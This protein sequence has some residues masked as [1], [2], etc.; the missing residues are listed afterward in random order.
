M[1]RLILFLFFICIIGISACQTASQVVAK[2]DPFTKSKVITLELWHKVVDGT[3]DNTSIIYRREIKDSQSIPSTATFFFRAVQYDLAGTSLQ[4][5]SPTA[6]ILIKDK[7]YKVALTDLTSEKTT[8][9][10]VEDLGKMIDAY[11]ST[12]K[13]LRGKISFTPE[14]EKQILEAD[15]LM[16]RFYQGDNASTLQAEPDQLAKV[17]EFLSA[18]RVNK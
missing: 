9:I 11:S 8:R 16:Y 10:D 15:S 3:L 18:G 2:D 1:K 17:K 12:W 6:Y 14:M 4:N 5:L 7:S 13:D